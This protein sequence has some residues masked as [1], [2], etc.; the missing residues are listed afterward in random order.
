MTNRTNIRDF[1]QKK[2]Y[3]VS[4][5]SLRTEDFDGTNAIEVFNLPEKALVT[6]AYVVA[7]VAGNSGLTL[8]VDVG[9]T[10][11]IAAADVDTLGDVSEADTNVV[12]GTGKTVSVTPSAAV[13]EGE[14][15][16]IVEYV[17]YTLG[18]GHLTN[19]SDN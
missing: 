13:T 4:A 17:E 8:K 9:T 19:Y 7:D 15:A 12:T 16:V 3:S 6:N 14:F 10:A 5:A 1:A 2:S 11:V 18:T